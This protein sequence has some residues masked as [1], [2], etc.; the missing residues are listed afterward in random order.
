M[1]ILFEKNDQLST[2]VFKVSERLLTD[3]PH[4][5]KRKQCFK[6][7]STRVYSLEVHQVSIT[8]DVKEFLAKDF[9]LIESV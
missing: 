1:V 7:I 6:V 5:V 4:K 3:I 2:N 8:L 9:V